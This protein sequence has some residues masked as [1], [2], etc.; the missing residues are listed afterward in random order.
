LAEFPEELVAYG[1]NE[2]LLATLFRQVQSEEKHLS[3]CLKGVPNNDFY[4]TLHPFLKKWHVTSR[5][6]K[7]GIG[8]F[9]MSIDKNLH[10]KTHRTDN[11][12][13]FIENVSRS[14]HSPNKQMEYGN[15]VEV[16]KELEKKLKEMNMEVNQLK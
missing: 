9:Y 12:Y 3:W 7:T 10:E 13:R 14:K 8:E 1:L 5:V 15:E 2:E 11:A 4:Q 6:S 16:H